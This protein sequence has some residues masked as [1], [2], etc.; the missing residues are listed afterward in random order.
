MSSMQGEKTLNQH[1][2][3]TGV[4]RA[5]NPPIKI[6]AMQLKEMLLLNFKRGGPIPLPRLYLYWIG[7][8]HTHLLCS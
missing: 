6:S 8:N 3:N 5:A 7:E 1:L 4:R 2:S